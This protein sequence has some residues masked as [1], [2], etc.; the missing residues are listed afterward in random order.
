MIERNDG[1]LREARRNL[2]RARGLWGMENP[3]VTTEPKTKRQQEVEK[4]KREPKPI[5]GRRGIM[6]PKFGAWPR[7]QER[8]II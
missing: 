1:S 8:L 3:I 2:D 6:P 4:D 5:P 7:R